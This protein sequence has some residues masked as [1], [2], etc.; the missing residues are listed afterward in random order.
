MSLYFS[1]AIIKN[2]YTD[3]D[4][5]SQIQQIEYFIL[6][7]EDD[8]FF[9]F[10]YFIIKRRK[11]IYLKIKIH[12]NLVCLFNSIYQLNKKQLQQLRE[13]KLNICIKYIQKVPF[14]KKKI[15]IMNNKIHVVL[16]Q[17]FLLLIIFLQLKFKSKVLKFSPFCREQPSKKTKLFE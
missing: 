5:S 15:K 17:A 14:M 1:E 11:Q 2:Y 4:C 16:H 3:Y 12:L 13:N 9:M 6:H 8:L 7:H 10:F